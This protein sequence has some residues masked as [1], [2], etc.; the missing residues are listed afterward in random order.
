M[1]SNHDVPRFA[2]RTC[3][4]DERKIRCALLALLTLRGTA[5][6]YQGDEI[7]LEQVDVPHDRIRDIDG[8]DACRTPLPWTG[9]G[10]WT[11]PWLPLGDTAR[12]VEDQRNDPGSILNFVRDTIAARRSNPDLQSGA[13]DPL[14]AQNGV[15]AYRR[16]S[17]VVALNLSDDVAEVEGRRLGPW[18]GAIL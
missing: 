6:L 15:W 12:N 16:G 11:D 13:Y 8:R 5:V 1:L 14:E 2:T 9:A 4:G 3:G 18:E 10:G 7:G 17:N